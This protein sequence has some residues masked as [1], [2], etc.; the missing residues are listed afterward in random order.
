MFLLQTGTVEV[1]AATVVDVVVD[2]VAAV[3][4]DMVAVVVVMEVEVA[5]DTAGAATTA[6]VEEAMEVT[7]AAVDMATARTKVPTTDME[8]RCV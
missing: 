6:V 5:L 4:E 7:R 8:I 1:A 2:M 3:V